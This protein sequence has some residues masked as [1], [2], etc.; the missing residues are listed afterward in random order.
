[1]SGDQLMFAAQARAIEE[2]TALT[3]EQGQRIVELERRLGQNSGNSSKPPSTDGPQAAARRSTR[4]KFGRKQGKRPG[5]EGRGCA[6][7]R[8]RT[9]SWSRAVGVRRL[10]RAHRCRAGR[11]A[12]SSGA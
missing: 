4:T 3:A 8:I 5:A 12:A 7:S 1:M 6:W 9:R 11:D 10:R 2:L